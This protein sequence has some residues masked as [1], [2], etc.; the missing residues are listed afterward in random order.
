MSG[1]TALIL[2]ATGATGKNLLKELLNSPKYTRVGEFGR[3]TTPL[4]TPGLENTDKLVQKTIDFEKLEAAGLADDKWDVVF[5]TMGTTRGNAGGIDKFIKIDQEYVVNAAQ[6][7]KRADHTQRLIYC[8]VF[9]ANRSSYAPYTKSK[10]QTEDRLASLGYSDTIVFRPGFLLSPERRESRPLETMALWMVTPLST[11]TASLGIN[12][13]SLAKSIRLA[14]ELG[15]AGLPLSAQATVTTGSDSTTKY[16]VVGNK[17]AIAL[18][19][20]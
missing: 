10:G 15:S 9:G 7:A 4:D 19:K 8:S 1:Q 16:T 14:G 13:G 18:S 2:G 5:I 11:L 6:A 12:V 17:G 20:L 3:R